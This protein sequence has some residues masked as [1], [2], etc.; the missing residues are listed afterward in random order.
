[1]TDVFNL[2][3][4]TRAVYRHFSDLE[5]RKRR[6]RRGQRRLDRLDARQRSV[7][8][9]I[10]AFLEQRTKDIVSTSQ[11]LSDRSLIKNYAPWEVG[12]S[13][14]HRRA[15]LGRARTSS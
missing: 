14:S 1:M 12:P 13:L 7:K 15:L 6:P 11:Q 9:A 5:L 10:L 2:E 4:Y 3:K 8:L